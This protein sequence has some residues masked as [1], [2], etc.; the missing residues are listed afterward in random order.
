MSND[1]RVDELSKKLDVSLDYSD[2]V[3]RTKTSKPNKTKLKELAVK[4]RRNLEE[5]SVEV[6]THPNTSI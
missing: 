4:I 5:S 6:T 3:D 2:K 1:E